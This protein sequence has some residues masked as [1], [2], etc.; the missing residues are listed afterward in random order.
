MGSAT[1]IDYR[2]IDM[3]DA[4]AICCIQRSTWLDTYVSRVNNISYDDVDLYTAA[5]TSCKNIQHFS[6]MI[7]AGQYVSWTVEC[8]K[9]KPCGHIKLVIENGDYNIDMLYV[10]PKFQGMSIGT[11]L[12]TMA[13]SAARS[14]NK[15]GSII[16]DVV[17]YNQRAINFYKKF[18]FKLVGSVSNQARPIRDGHA[19]PLKRFKLHLKY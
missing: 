12:I 15:S 16:V 7:A 19:L 14:D 5:W 13:I 1:E 4:A 10:D 17:S 6:S 11:T 3:R 8:K 9:D 2:S 18:G